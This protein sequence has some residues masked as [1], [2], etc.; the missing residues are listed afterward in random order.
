MRNLEPEDGDGS[1][2]KQRERHPTEDQTK[3]GVQPI[4][5]CVKLFSMILS[6]PGALPFLWS[7]GGPGVST[8]TPTSSAVHAART[9]HAFFIDAAAHTQ[10][11]AVV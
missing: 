3:P 5:R 7:R 4:M 11:M 6:P 2:E 10:M 9:H 1:G 8:V